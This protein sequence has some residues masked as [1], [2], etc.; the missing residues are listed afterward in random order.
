MS[1]D[2]SAY[3]STLFDGRPIPWPPWACKAPDG[4]IHIDNRIGRIDVDLTKSPRRSVDFH[5]THNFG[6]RVVADSWLDE[7]RDLIDGSRIFL[8]DVRVVGKK[9][10]GWSTVHEP[11]APPLLASEGT[12]KICP[13]CGDYYTTL[14]GKLSIGDPTAAGRP[15]FSNDNGIFI[16]EDLVLNRKI[17]KPTGVFKP[18]PVKLRPTPKG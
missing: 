11:G 9:I 7:I 15:L 12:S 16:R 17:R 8:G 18:W 1:L 6:V 3:P 4:G 2:A 10:A 13:I 14:W 5:W